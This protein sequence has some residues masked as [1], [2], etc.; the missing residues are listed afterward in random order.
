DMYLSGDTRQRIYGGRISLSQC[1]IQINNRSRVLKLNYRT[2][3]EIYNFAMQLQKEYQYDDMDGKSMSKDQSTCIFHGP[4]PFLRRFSDPEEE[5]QE[6]IRHIRKLMDASVLPSDIAVM[7]RS[8]QLL[9]AMRNRLERNGLQVLSVTSQQPDDKSIP[10][11]RLMTMH[12]GKGMEYAYVY[13][14]CLC[15]DILPSRRDLEKAADEEMLHEIYLSEANLLSVAIT[16][17]K[18][19]VWLSYSGRPS[20]LMERYIR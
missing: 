2:T 20:E 11:V 13:L 4:A 7:V 14:P 3:E 6:M 18:K 8:N 15:R 1:G 5:A 16:R 17:A 12:R 9:Y 10:G 19:Q